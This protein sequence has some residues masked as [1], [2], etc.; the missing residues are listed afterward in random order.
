MSYVDIDGQMYFRSRSYELVPQQMSLYVSREE[1]EDAK[2]ELIDLRRKKVELLDII[3]EE[4]RERDERITAEE[5]QAIMLPVEIVDRRIK[6]LSYLISNARIVEKSSGVQQ[7]EIET[8][9]E[10]D[11][12][13]VERIPDGLFFIKDGV[14]V[15]A[16]PGNRTPFFA[17][18]DGEYIGFN[19]LLL[20]GWMLVDDSGRRIETISE[21]WDISKK[22]Y[23]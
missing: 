23:L 5:L 2:K 10:D 9:V 8:L 1:L 14:K 11:T 20:N 12:P 6:E 16:K 21:A 15:E 19:R 3:E 13:I 17:F 22:V 18:V 7:E 4:K